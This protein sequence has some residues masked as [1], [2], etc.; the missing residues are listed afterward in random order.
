[1][2]SQRL[3]FDESL[4]AVLAGVWPLAGVAE[5]VAFEAGRVFVRLAAVGAVVGP[6]NVKTKLRKSFQ[7]CDF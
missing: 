5:S 3:G 2:T 4:A 7:F 1:V 6:V